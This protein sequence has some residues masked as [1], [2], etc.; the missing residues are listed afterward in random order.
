[1]SRLPP[2]EPTATPTPEPT[3]TPEP[4]V[5]P[6]P[7]PTAAPT[8]VDPT[9]GWPSDIEAKDLAGYGFAVTSTDTTQYE[10]TGWQDI[11]GVTYYYDPATHQPVTGQQVI[12]ATSTPSVRTAR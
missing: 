4:T 8:P 1:M 11:D 12:Q 5:T 3:A 6:T 2:P 7:E 10:Y 9:A